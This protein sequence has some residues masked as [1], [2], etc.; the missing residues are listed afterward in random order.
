MTHPAKCLKRVHLVG[1]VIALVALIGASAYWGFAQE[2]RNQFIEGLL[3][4]H[5]TQLQGAGLRNAFGPNA[6]PNGTVN[7]S[8]SQTRALSRITESFLRQLAGNDYTMDDVRRYKGNA[9]DGHAAPGEIGAN[10]G[11]A[12]WEANH[13][14]TERALM[15]GRQIVVQSCWELGMADFA[16]SQPTDAVMTVY[17]E[18]NIGSWVEGRTG[19]LIFESDIDLSSLSSNAQVNADLMRSIQARLITRTRMNMPQINAI[20][21][22]HGQGGADVYI[23]RWG[24]AWAEMDLLRRGSCR[25]IQVVEEGG[26]TTVRFRPT[27]GEQLLW[28]RAVREGAEPP[29]ITLREEPMMSL[30]LNRHI[31]LEVQHALA[32]EAI[33]PY[34]AAQAAVKAVKL[35]LRSYLTAQKA[36]AG[37]WDPFVEN[38]PQLATALRKIA[39]SSDP[40]EI[41]RYLEALTGGR[42]HEAATAEQATTVIVEMMQQVQKA[43]DLNQN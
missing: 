15:R 29:R 10:V 24:Q 14:A 41:A 39:G 23:G 28:E 1:R 11:G 42:L 36:G 37:H 20:I 4:Q 21:T 6:D 31:I 18:M 8:P 2:A 38:N 9:R 34:T 43:V 3:G 19:K 13:L 35:A 5:S 32:G 30:E 27:T 17:G 16:Q 12:W 33:G 26:Q 25:L 40:V 22:A 7:L